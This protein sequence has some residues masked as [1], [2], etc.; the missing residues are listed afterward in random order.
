MAVGHDYRKD[1]A[2][3]TSLAYNL[4][5]DEDH[6]ERMELA[7]RER[8]FRWAQRR[9]LDEQVAG[10]ESKVKEQLL[11]WGVPEEKIPTL[12]GSALPQGVDTY[13]AGGVSD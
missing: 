9:L 3:F 11:S 12:I 6:L 10:A 4:P 8:E 13:R 1:L 2:R 7:L 5:V